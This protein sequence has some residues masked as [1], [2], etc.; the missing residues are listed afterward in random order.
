MSQDRHRTALLLGATVAGASP[1]GALQASKTSAGT[2]KASNPER[3]EELPQALF[4]LRCWLMA[5]V[6]QM[7]S[8]FI[9]AHS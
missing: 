6:I 8:L 7:P 9:L 3:S 5:G 2:L 4:G 1:I